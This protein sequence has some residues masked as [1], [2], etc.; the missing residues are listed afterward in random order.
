MTVHAVEDQHEGFPTIRETVANAMP[1]ASLSGYENYADPVIA[2]LVEREHQICDNLIAF[3]VDQGL[4]QD[5]AEAALA[6][7]GLAVRPAPTFEPEPDTD[8]GLTELLHRM[9][10]LIGEVED[11]LRR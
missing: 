10:G 8:G 5:A 11:K 4:S 6:E 7:A 2:D 9:K 1:G 3:A